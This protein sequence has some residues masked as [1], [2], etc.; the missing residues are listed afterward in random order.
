MNFNPDTIIQINSALESINLIVVGEVH[1]VVENTEVIKDLVE[2]IG[3]KNVGFIGVE[4]PKILEKDIS[5]LPK[6]KKEFLSNHLVKLLLEDG[7]CSEAH[8]KLFEFLNENGIKTVCLDSSLA[9]WN[10]RDRGMYQNLINIKNKLLDK[11]QK[12]IVV[13]GNLHAR[14]E[15]FTLENAEYIPFASHL[16]KHLNI[17]LIYQTGY[18]YNKGMQKFPKG[19][20]SEVQ[21]KKAGDMEFLFY[22]TKATPTKKVKGEKVKLTGIVL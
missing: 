3:I 4:Y 7:R 19:Q 11:K 5:L 9:N 14:K 20:D 12:V 17:Q 10:E 16:G 15:K 6:N 18:F 8:I 13:T 2:I 1:G 21:L 22:L